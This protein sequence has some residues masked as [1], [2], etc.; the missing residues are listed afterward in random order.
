[1]THAIRILTRAL[2]AVGMVLFLGAAYCTYTVESDVSYVPGYGYVVQVQ[3]DF[4][5]GAGTAEQDHFFVFGTEQ[6][7][8]QYIEEVRKNPNHNPGP[9]VR[10]VGRE[11]NPDTYRDIANKLPTPPAL[12]RPDAINRAIDRVAPPVPT[13]PAPQ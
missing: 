13:G 9:G 2:A 6:E 4:W 3:K 8:R 7:A 10:Q 1:M 11:T 12:A 5:Y